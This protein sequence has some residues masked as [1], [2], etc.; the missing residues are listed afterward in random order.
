MYEDI[1]LTTIQKKELLLEKTKTMNLLSDTFMSVALNDTNA[2]QH[3]LRILTGIQDLI[4]KE[5]RTQHKISKL[6][7]HNAI[8]DVLAEDSLGRLYNIEIQ[9]ADTLDHARRTRF[10]G[11]MI[12]S[13]YLMKG[14]N[15][16]DLPD[17]YII[18]VSETDLWKS[19]HTSYPVE[20]YFQSTNMP[21]N[22]GLHI[23][24]INA[25]VNDGTKIAELMQYFKSS[26]PNDMSQGDLSKRVHFL[27][28]DEG[29]QNIMCK[30]SEEIYNL[31]QK[32]IVLHM[33]HSGNSPE[34]IAQL[35]GID[36]EVV[37]QWI[38]KGDSSGCAGEA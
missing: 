17:V 23:I 37:K 31:G 15:Y 12:D 6:A 10:Y 36:V 21:Y 25:A 7:S 34:Q 29:G 33:L 28:C 35:T 14:A 5:V 4:V 19:G 24:Y 13:E 38:E 1:H 18:Y 26:D 27:K 20:K 2:C 32:E 30:V 16:S 22:D 11:S 9:R 3:V 8:L